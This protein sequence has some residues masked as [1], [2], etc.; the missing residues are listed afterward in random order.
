MKANLTRRR[1]VKGGTALATAGALV[2]P[3]LLEWATAWAQTVPWKPENGAQLSFLRWKAFVPAE[4]DGCMAVMNAFTKA[5]RVRV[6]IIR[7]SNDDVQAK[8]LVAANTGAGPDLFWGLSS[9]PHLFPQ[10]CVDVSDV[11]EYLGKKYGGWE[12]RSRCTATLAGLRT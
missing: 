6:N 7:E 1:L 9:L 8:A 2:L 11:A 12:L 4:D 5:T 10:K 3:A